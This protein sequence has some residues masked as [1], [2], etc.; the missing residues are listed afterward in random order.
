MPLSFI[1]LAQV[2]VALEKIHELLVTD[3]YATKR[4][5]F[6]NDVD[7]FEKQ[8]IL[9]CVIDDLACL[10]RVPRR[11]LHVVKV[12]VFMDIRYQPVYWQIQDFLL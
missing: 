1:T 6:Y 12:A 10:F 8:Q 7:L 3:S 4:D 9:D 2:A 5:L 11:C